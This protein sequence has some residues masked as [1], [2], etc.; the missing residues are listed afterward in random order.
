MEGHRD[1]GKAHKIKRKKCM[2]E[3]TENKIGLQAVW[4]FHIPVKLTET[5]NK[6]DRVKTII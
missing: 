2:D 3:I 6:N 4:G 1:G 5:E